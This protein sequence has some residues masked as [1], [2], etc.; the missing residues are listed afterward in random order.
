MC[1]KSKTWDCPTVSICVENEQFLLFWII[2][3]YIFSGVE[4]KL[5][6]VFQLF[7]HI[8]GLSLDLNS[9]LLAQLN[10]RIITE[11]CTQVI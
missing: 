10:I 3:I 9:Q 8:I 11:N 4:S 6:N 1:F 2:R 5:F 7:N